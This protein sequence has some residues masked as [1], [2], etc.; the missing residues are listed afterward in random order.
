VTVKAPVPL[1]AAAPERSAYKR[2]LLKLGGEYLV[3]DGRY[4]IDPRAAERLATMLANAI[5][6]IMQPH[7]EAS[8]ITSTAIRTSRDS[9]RRLD[10]RRARHQ[11]ATA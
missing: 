3:G 10:R 11:R 1:R 7:Q 6:E 8:S 2:V 4:G 5:R 9:D